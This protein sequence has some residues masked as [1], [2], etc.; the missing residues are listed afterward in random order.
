MTTVLDMIKVELTISREALLRE[1]AMVPDELTNARP[2]DDVWSAAEILDHLAAVERRVGAFLAKSI[3]GRPDDDV[4]PDID[5]DVFTRSV[6][7]LFATY[8]AGPVKSTQV[9]SRDSSRAQLLETLEGTR[10]DLLRLIDAARGIDLSKIKGP[11]PVLGEL[12]LY[13]FL[14]FIARHEDRHRGQITRLRQALQL[15]A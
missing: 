2:V 12:D 15:Q 6:D 13:Q 4:I 11:H 5:P 3:E 14:M 7:A 10:T 1:F 8:A 9:P